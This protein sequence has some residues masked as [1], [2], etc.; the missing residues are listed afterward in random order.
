MWSHENIGNHH[1]LPHVASGGSSD[2]L[3]PTFVKSGLQFHTI[4]I[5]RTKCN[6]GIN[7]RDQ[8][9]VVHLLQS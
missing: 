4:A 2:N 8:M 5:R 3:G 7:V 9:V 1:H 6:G